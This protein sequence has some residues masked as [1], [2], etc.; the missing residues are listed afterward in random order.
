MIPS[1]VLTWCM[2]NGYGKITTTQP[3]GGGCI[4]HGTRLATTSGKTFFLKT[5][6]NAPEMMFLR[7]T[8]G[9]HALRTQD[10]PIVPQ[11]H[12]YGEDFILMEDLAPA[13]PMRDYWGSFGRRLAALHEH[14]NHRF[15]FEHDNYIGSTAQPNT[16][17]SDGFAFFSQNRLLFQAGLARQRSLINDDDCKRIESITRRL[18]DLVPAQPSS[19]IHGDLWS[20]NAITDHLGQPAIIDP[21]V[22]YGWGEAELGMTAL[23]GGFPNEFYR[24]YEEVRPLTPGWRSR[25]PIYNL[26]HLLNHVNLFGAG[27]LSQTRAILQKFT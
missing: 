11:V 21:A 15:G 16:W 22:Y 23:F 9:L 8:E 5:N 20:G 12:C 18:A 25:L 13:A 24:T 2:D 10:G 3:V 27:Y 14:T 17:N 6:P 1:Q 19:L 26:Y 4:N 7:E